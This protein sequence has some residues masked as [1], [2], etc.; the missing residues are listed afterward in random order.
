MN[1]KGVTFIELL[2]YIALLAIISLLIGRQ[3]KLLIG[4]YSSGK[5]VTKLQTDSRDILG[6]MVREIRNMGMKSY[7]TG[8]STLTKKIQTGITVSGS[9]LSSFIHTQQSGGGY[10][11]TLEFFKIQVDNFGDHDYTDTI[12]YYVDGTTLM[13]DLKSSANPKHTNSVVAENVYALQF[14]YGVL[15]TNEPV[16]DQS[17]L[18]S[19]GNSWTH[20][21]TPTPAYNSSDITLTFDGAKSGYL[22]YPKTNGTGFPISANRKY[23]V[24][25]QIDPSGGFPKNLTSMEISFRNFSNTQTYGSETFKPYSAGAT[26]TII[27]PVHTGAEDAYAYL[28]Y[29]SSGAGTLVVNGVEV[30]CTELGAYDWK[31]DPTVAEKVNVRAIRMYVLTRTRDKAASGVNTDIM[32]GE[33]SVPRSGEYS[34]RLYT[35]TIETPN[36]GIF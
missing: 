9:D 4:N 20:G 11:D 10:N 6:L 35:E 28:H 19:P 27:V 22:K 23:S 34:Y 3:F 16:F 8:G 33:I 15:A 5:R 14:Q 13:R 25:L 36:N 31:N 17:S 12:Q 32:V 1:K 24:M 18:S 30:R 21:G 26:M 7:F 29:T 2:I